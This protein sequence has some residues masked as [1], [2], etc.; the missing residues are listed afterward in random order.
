MMMVHRVLL[1]QRVV[2]YLLETGVVVLILKLCVVMMES[3]VVLKVCLFK[4]NLKLVVAMLR[5]IRT[6]VEPNVRMIEIL[7]KFFTKL[8]DIL[9]QE[10][11]HFESQVKIKRQDNE[12]NKLLV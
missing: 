9:L 12:M 11:K 1:V 4:K 7:C 6:S 3:T 10:L 2:S 8:I 5:P